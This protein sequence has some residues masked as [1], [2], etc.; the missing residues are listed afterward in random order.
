MSEQLSSVAR[1]FFHSAGTRDNVFHYP[2]LTS[3]LETIL[4]GLIKMFKANSGVFFIR[5]HNSPRFLDTQNL[6]FVNSSW[7]Y[8]HE[9]LN[10]YYQLDPFL[11]TIPGA[12]ACRDRSNAF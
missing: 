11:K 7:H 1:E 10:H 8:T 6:A 12:S 3:V 5:D 9:Y 4:K 2:S